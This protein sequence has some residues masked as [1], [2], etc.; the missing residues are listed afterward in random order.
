MRLAGAAMQSIATE[1]DGRALDAARTQS[2]WGL[3]ILATVIGLAGCS[4]ADTQ[5][6]RPAPPEPPP[7]TGYMSSL[8]PY[9]IQM[10]D[11]LAIRLLQNPELDEEVVVRPDGDISTTVVQNVRAYGLTIPELD[12]ELRRDYAKYLGDRNRP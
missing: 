1:P 9:R 11:V 7:Y 10:G 2:L 5:R 12:A 4:T 3:V 8:P 6:M